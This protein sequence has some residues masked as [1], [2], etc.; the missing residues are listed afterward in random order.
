MTTEEN[1][2]KSVKTLR[3]ILHVSDSDFFSDTELYVE[4]IQI[5]QDEIDSV[6][7]TFDFNLYAEPNIVNISKL[8]LDLGGV[9]RRNL[10][11]FS[12]DKKGILKSHNDNY[13][14]YSENLVISVNFDMTDEKLRILLSTLWD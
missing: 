14:T 13:I 6:F 9:L 5:Y 10:I 2:K 3:N 4:D 12:F 8:I 1:L 11:K 7:I